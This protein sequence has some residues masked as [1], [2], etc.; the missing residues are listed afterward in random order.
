MTEENSNFITNKIQSGVYT[1]SQKR[2]GRSHIWN[3]LA[4]IQKEDGNFLDGLVYCRVCKQ[5]LKYSASQ[6]SNLN[7]H[8]CC[9]AEKEVETLKTVD[10]E[11]KK[12][13]VV[14]CTSWIVEDCR[15]FSVVNGTGF[16]KLAKFFIELGAKYGKNVDVNK[17]LPDA[18]TISRN[19]I[20]QA[21]E[22][23]IKIK[24]EICEVVSSGGASATIDMWTDNYVKRNFLGVTLHY[25]KQDKL[26]DIILGVKSMDFERS[27][28][29]NIRLKLKSLLSEFGVNNFE[30]LKFITDR[31]SNI[32]KAL[33]PNIRLNCSSHLLSNILDKSFEETEEL[34][35]ILLACKKIVKY[36]KKANLQH[37]LST[38]LKTPCPTRWN[39]NY[40]MLKSIVDNWF[41][42]NELL[43]EKGENQRL[44]LINISTLKQL[45]EILEDFQIVFK[46]L[47]LCSS[48]SLCFVIPSI[49][50]IK[51]LCS[52]DNADI[53]AIATLKKNI[54]NKIDSV[55]AKNLSLWHKAAYFLYPPAAK[56][57]QDSLPEIKNFCVSQINNFNNFPSSSNS[58][59]SISTPT[60][61]STPAESNT[62]FS[63]SEQSI[64]NLSTSQNQKHQKMDIQFFFSDLLEESTNTH[65][66]TPQEEVERY[67]KETVKITEDFD[68]MNWW[69]THAIDYP[70]LSKFALQVHAI[71]ASSAA[72]ERAFSLAGNVITAKRN[73]IGPKSVDSLLFL[74]SYFRNFEN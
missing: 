34:A 25:Q 14:A 43:T 15:P 13:A 26:V 53:P 35:E 28:A 8:K 12:A 7:R 46:K 2:K 41:M 66:E 45:L 51:S 18:T 19:A 63:F 60:P 3:V 57:Q 4:E 39:S 73:R 17:M 24:D 56:M 52:P 72:S 6:T 61:P 38:S 33:E 44:L 54:F 49:N 37:R 71:P 22:F 31:G 29:D 64:A 9:R 58:Q 47:Q 21:N 55:W 74:H 10:A 11:D 30:F 68:V 16:E 32:V 65:V 69:K 27:T 62:Q 40:F 48:P 50:K 5:L 70:Y 42:I 23:K 1:L 20:K 67:S 36:F 59:V